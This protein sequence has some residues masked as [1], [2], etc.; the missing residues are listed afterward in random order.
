[1]RIVFLVYRAWRAQCPISLFPS[2]TTPFTDET[3]PDHEGISQPILVAVFIS[4]VSLEDLRSKPV[5]P[6]R[7]IG[8]PQARP[9]PW[10]LDPFARQ[11]TIPLLPK[12]QGRVR[13]AATSIA[14]IAFRPR[15]LASLPGLDQFRGRRWIVLVSSRVLPILHRLPFRTLGDDQCRQADVPLSP[16]WPLHSDS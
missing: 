6:S 15:D 5:R 9:A 7:R 2:I 10:H 3:G 4:Y 1:L 12:L 14:S 13:W 16:M 11:Q 8:S